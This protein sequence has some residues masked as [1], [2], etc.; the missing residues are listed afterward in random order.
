M[1]GEYHA[2]GDVYLSQQPLRFTNYASLEKTM[3]VTCPSCGTPNQEVGKYCENCGFFIASPDAQPQVAP[4]SQPQPQAQPQPQSQPAG[5]ALDVP[6]GIMAPT[7]GVQAPA[8]SAQ[9]AVVRAGKANPSEGFTIT[10]MGEYLLGRP[11]NE[12]GTLVD[13]DVRQWVQPMD[14]QGQ[15]Q[16]LVHRRQCYLGIGSDGAVTVRAFPGSELDT[17]VKPANS[18]TFTPL[19]TFGS[20]R[21][22]RPD[23]TYALEPGDQVFMGDPEAL[24]LFQ[25]GDPTAA[26][27]YLV[28]ELLSRTL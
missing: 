1:Q 26:N 20:V 18:N 15:K 3:I 21:D 23:S 27:N 6:T 2:S 11:D 24:P 16:Y 22:Q 5:A 4:V 7:P 8:G 28:L 10:R 17:L 19:H 14:M 25:S 12:S 13:I 9:F